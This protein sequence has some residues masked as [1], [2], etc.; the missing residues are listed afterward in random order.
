[1]IDSYPVFKHKS[2]KWFSPDKYDEMITNLN[3]NVFKTVDFANISEITNLLRTYSET[4]IFGNEYYVI[5]MDIFDPMGTGIRSA[6][7][8]FL[9]SV[10]TVTAIFCGFTDTGNPLLKFD[11]LFIEVPQLVSS[12]LTTVQCTTLISDHSEI[13][14]LLASLM[15]KFEDKLSS[16]EKFDNSYIH[17]LVHNPD[18]RR[19]EYVFRHEQMKQWI[20][21]AEIIGAPSEEDL[22]ISEMVD[23]NEMG[24]IQL[25]TYLI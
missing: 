5:V 3:A 14:C 16:L 17:D 22:M 4:P 7:K 11:D 12:H 15:L 18:K 8:K 21:D 9:G 23:M 10:S 2:V 24:K 13:E 1:M 20:K 19:S 6:V 25:N